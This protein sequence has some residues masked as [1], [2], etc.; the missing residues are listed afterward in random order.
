MSFDGHAVSSVLVAGVRDRVTR[1]ASTRVTDL[2][3]R[4]CRSSSTLSQSAGFRMS[5][6]HESEPVSVTPPAPTQLPSWVADRDRRPR[7]CTN[8]SWSPWQPAATVTRSYQYTVVAAYLDPL[9]NSVTVTAVGAISGV[10]L[11][12]SSSCSTDILNPDILRK[13]CTLTAQVGDVISYTITVTNTGDEDL[14]AITVDDSLLGDLS[15]S[16]ADESRW[17]TRSRTSSPTRSRPTV[18]TRSRTK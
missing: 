14:E 13:T 4:A 11:T 2:R 16:F 18:R 5:V 8:T 1:A 3:G 9:P 7:R 17:V 15:G 12:G 6:S 10:T